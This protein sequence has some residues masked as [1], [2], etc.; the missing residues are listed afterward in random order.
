MT[1]ETK[2]NIGDTVWFLKNN[3]VTSMEVWCIEVSATKIYVK[4]T[5]VFFRAATSQNEGH[6]YFAEE[7]CFQ[8]KEE[9]LQ[10]L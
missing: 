7:D 10:S 9:L 4:P 1:I 6:L 3:K 2:F 5:Y 8:T